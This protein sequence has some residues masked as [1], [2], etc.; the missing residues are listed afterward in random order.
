M[1]LVVEPPLADE[2]NGLR[3]A[4]GDPGLARIAPH[5][6][7]VPPVN[8]RRAD[9]PAAL[10]RMRSAAEGQTAALRL[11][12]G[13]V[14][15]FL[16]TNPVLYLAVGGDLDRLRRLREAVFAP[17]F[18]RPVSW[19]WVPHLTI[20]DGVAVERIDAGLVALGSYAAVADIGRMVVLEE[21]PG[22]VWRPLADAA[23]GRPVRVG[24]GGLAVEITA[25]RLVDP[26]ILEA[27][28]P[29]AAPTPLDPSF[30][31]TARREDEPVAAGVGWLDA[32]G[33]HVAVWVRPEHRRQGLG[34]QVLAHLEATARRQG[35]SH[36]WLDAVGPSGFYRAVSSWS[37]AGYSNATEE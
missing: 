24:T 3:R 13:S 31:L 5:V 21:S 29:Q 26:E 19:P 28:G 25:G 1:V 22:R 11:T 30:V 16:P 32:A 23:L 20:A 35:W 4:L 36:P 14:S 34:G 9:L 27:A 10:R 15:S 17:P 8:I 12:F 7:L 6:T 2:I 33:P 37:R 18:E